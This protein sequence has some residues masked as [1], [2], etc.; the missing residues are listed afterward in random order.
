MLRVCLGIF[1]LL[2]KGPKET[3]GVESKGVDLD[4]DVMIAVDGLGDLKE[5]KAVF[6]AVYGEGD[7]FHGHLECW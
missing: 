7:G 2:R 1:I 6:R 3:Y 5:L 4:E